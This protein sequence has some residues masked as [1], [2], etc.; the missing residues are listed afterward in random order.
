MDDF[1]SAEAQVLFLERK[2]FVG[3]PVTPVRLATARDELSSS[4]LIYQVM[5]EIANDQ[6]LDVW[7]LG[8]VFYELFCGERPPW[9]ENAEDFTS[10]LSILQYMDEVT[11]KPLPGGQVPLVDVPPTEP[12]EMRRLIQRMLVQK[13]GNRLTIHQVYEEFIDILRA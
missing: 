6:P 11:F 10:P 7:S 9:I 5:Q 1:T 12:P 3:K 2:M 13:D 8:V 4:K